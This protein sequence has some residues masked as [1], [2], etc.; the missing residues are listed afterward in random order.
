MIDLFSWPTPNGLKISI[1]LAEA[2]VEHKVHPV[3]IRKGEQFEPAFLA[4]SPNN[5]IPAIVDNAPADGGGPISVFESG[6]ILQYLA[7]K[8][9]QF[10]GSDLRT[11]TEI[12]QWLMWQMGGLGPMLG[13]NG[14]FNVYA[15]EPVPY[16]IGRYVN[17]SKRLYG[18]LDKQLGGRDYIAGDYSIADMACYPWIVLYNAHKIDLASY[19]NVA[20]W[21]ERVATRPAVVQ[22]YAEKDTLYAEDHA[23]MT[24]EERAKLFGFKK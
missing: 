18:V 14:H 12:T 24:D 3:S 8:T 23:P 2:G 15:P 7:E 13:Q 11:K 17:E 16:A 4:I 20:A 10:G 1:F 5:R 9:G 6:A 22:V 19:P 21:F